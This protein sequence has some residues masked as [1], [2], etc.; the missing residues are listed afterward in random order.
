MIS[1][2][3]RLA[4]ATAVQLVFFIGNSGFLVGRKRRAAG[5]AP[6]KKRLARSLP[7]PSD[8]YKAPKKPQ[9]PV[10]GFFDA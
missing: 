7:R 6:N 9:S 10:G 3:R 8:S 5:P 2:S 4:F 1:Q